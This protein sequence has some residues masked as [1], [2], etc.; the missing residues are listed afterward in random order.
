[1]ASL[2]LGSAQFGMNY[3]IMNTT[4]C[5][6]VS[7]VRNILKSASE[8]QIDLI[9]TAAA[10]GDSETVLGNFDLSRYKIVTKLKLPQFKVTRSRLQSSFDSCLSRLNVG[11]IYALMAHEP[12]DLF[13][14]NSN[15]FISLAQS[16]KQRGIIKKFG[17]SVYDFEDLTKI[18]ELTDIDIIQAPFNLFDQRLVKDGWIE[19]LNEKQIEVHVRSLFLQG[20]MLN[21][22]SNLPEYFKPWK[23]KFLLLEE[24]SKELKI[25]KQAICL[26]LVKFFKNIEKAIVGVDSQ[27]HLEETIA[28]YND[29]IELDLSIFACDDKNLILPTRWKN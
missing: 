19:L 27:Q 8:A 20:T 18:M 21:K 5:P 28:A 24:T 4:G 2:G 3:G 1:M 25:N 6:E 9:D 16:L 17:V 10:Y 13:G 7:D 11:Q 12:T 26:S 29:A 15:L 23:S 22:S 14:C